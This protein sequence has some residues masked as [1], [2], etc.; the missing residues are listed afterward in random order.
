MQR[1]TRG[2]SS[3]RLARCLTPANLI[4]GDNAGVPERRIFGGCLLPTPEGLLSAAVALRSAPD[5]AQPAFL[6]RTDRSVRLAARQHNTVPESL[7]VDGLASDP[8]YEYIRHYASAATQALGEVELPGG[9]LSRAILTQYWK[10]LQTVVPSGLD[11]PE[12]PV[13]D[14]DPSLHVLLRPTLAPKLLARTPF[15]SGAVAAK[16]AATVAGLRDALHRIQQ[17]MF[18]MRPA[19]PSRPSTDTALR[20]NELLAYVSVLYRWASWMLWR[21]SW[22]HRLSPSNRRFLPLGGSPE[23]PAETFARH[24]DRGPSGTNGSM[25]CMALRAA[26]S[27]VL[28]HLTRLANLWQTGKRSGGTYG[29]VDTVVSTVEVLS[30]VHHHAQYIIN[31]T[32]TGYGVWATDS[33]NNEYLRAAVDSQERFCRTTAPLFPTM[34]A[35]SWARMELSIKAWFGAALAADLLRSGA[36]SLHYESILRLVASRRTT[37]SAGLPDD[38]GRGPGGHRAG[39]GTRREKIWRARRDNEPRPPR[40]RLHSTPALT[41]RFRRRCADGG[42][43]G[44]PLPDADDPVTEPP[45]RPQPATYYTHMGEVLLRLPARNGAGPDRRPPVATCPL[46]VRRASLGSLDR[47]R[48]WGPAPEGEPDQMEATYLTA[49]DDDARHKATHAASARERHAPYEDDESIYETVS[50]D[51]GRVYEEIPWMR[52]YENVCANTANAAPASPYI[53]AEN[54][55]YDWGGSALFSPPGLHWAPA[56]AVEPSPVLARHR[57]NALTNDGPTNVAALSALLTK[58]KREGRRSR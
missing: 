43:R 1:R 54:P 16:Y 49:D 21:T 24:L 17:Y 4:R 42:N 40:P 18:F 45:A 29:T 50:E 23:A 57:A 38:S 25:Q 19:D 44:S 34:T 51:G 55:L 27:D 9:Q 58:L 15:K 56:P 30:I 32:L 41:R 14:C 31:A 36:P 11:V 8:H 2:A 35:P 33:L 26:V 6:T 53:E 10:Y 46:L 37:W 47:P 7:I 39:G 13:G 20:L 48:V 28:G 3:L 52:V 22:R 12:D 5:D